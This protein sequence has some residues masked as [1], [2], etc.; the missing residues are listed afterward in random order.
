MRN[1]E[2]NIIQRFWESGCIST[3]TNLIFLIEGF[4][5]F[6]FFNFAAM[7]LDRKFIL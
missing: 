1:F 3:P 4:Q 5:S 6:L 2:I 7:S